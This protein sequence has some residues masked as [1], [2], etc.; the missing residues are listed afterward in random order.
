MAGERPGVDRGVFS[1][2]LGLRV[3]Q[4]KVPLV[5]QGSWKSQPRKG[6]AWKTKLPGLGSGRM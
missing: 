2:D 6:Q 1:S 5:P 3:F 4:N